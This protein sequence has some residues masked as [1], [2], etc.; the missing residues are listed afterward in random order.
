MYGQLDYKSDQL[1]A[2]W[3]VS[4]FQCHDFSLPDLTPPQAVQRGLA[5]KQ[6]NSEV[7]H[8]TDGQLNDLKA[9]GRALPIDSAD[10]VSD[11]YIGLAHLR[12]PDAQRKEREARIAQ[13]LDAFFTG[14]P[15]LPS[16]VAGI[17]HIK[18][19]APLTPDAYLDILL[20][21]QAARLQMKS[22]DLTEWIVHCG[23]I[24]DGLDSM[25]SALGIEAGSPAY[26]LLV[27][28]GFTRPWEARNGYL[29]LLA[30]A[31]K[32]RLGD[33]VI[34]TQA[35]LTSADLLIACEG[36]LLVS[37][38][39][40]CLKA[41]L[42]GS[43]P[44]AIDEVVDNQA[45]LARTADSARVQAI[46]EATITA[47]CSGVPLG[48]QVQQQNL[49]A[50]SAAHQVW[51]QQMLRMTP[52][53]LR[54]HMQGPKLPAPSP[55]SH[56]E[57]DVA[58]P[59]DLDPVSAWSVSRLLRWIEGPI[60]DGAP[61]RLDRKAIVA[62][63]KVARQEARAKTKM[64]DKVARVDLDLTE[65]DV[66]L[67]VQNAL[68]TTAEFFIGDLDDMVFRAKTLNIASPALQ[69]CAG[70]SAALRTMVA[71]P[72]SDDQKVRALL[73]QAETAINLLRKEMCAIEIDVLS[74]QRFAQRFQQALASEPMVEGKR[75]GGVI[76]CPMRRGDWAWVAEQYH[77][78]WL[79]WIKQIRVDGV[80]QPLQPDQALGLYVTGK[81]LSGF[82]FDISVHLWQRRPG[83]HGTPGDGMTP[84]SPMNTVDWIDT[85][86]P[87]AV[88]HVPSAG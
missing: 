19:L 27:N 26:N 56:S 87:C 73:H 37:V 20:R 50:I 64:P 28:A 67:A 71:H 70:L 49:A 76:G 82:E 83:R 65:T 12:L 63:E 43:T 34:K 22:L 7:P 78:R 79:P 21:S 72:V 80:L 15:P 24:V 77:Q 48:T 16:V 53:R 45:A 31:A 81:S 86:T 69:A 42:D 60:S 8:L 10:L 52:Q 5:L 54:T 9:I 13:T 58:S 59:A 41:G 25:G 66:E 39:Q 84:F 4:Y 62:R 61:Q 35:A 2:P 23:A 18:L 38:L 3:I 68:N 1:E 57:N 47:T 55:G 17:N 32:H 51:W 30:Q 40:E 44:A 46:I 36:D 6:V 33:A 14:A 29:E 85:L 74:R 88:L 75:H 11:L